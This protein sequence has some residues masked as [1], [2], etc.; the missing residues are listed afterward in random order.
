MSVKLLHAFQDWL[1]PHL[2]HLLFD[3]VGQLAIDVPCDRSAAEQLMALAAEPR[4]LAHIS[5]PQH[6]QHILAALVP[7][8]WVLWLPAAAAW[9]GCGCM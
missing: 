7:P 8:G 1:K 4:L 3:G 2:L 6:L 9:C 5:Q